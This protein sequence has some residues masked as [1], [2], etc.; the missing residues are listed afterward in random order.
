[1][2]GEALGALGT[3]D[4]CVMNRW[5]DPELEQDWPDWVGDAEWCQVVGSEKSSGLAFGERGDPIDDRIAPN[6]LDAARRRFFSRRYDLVW[7]AEPRGYQPVAELASRPL[8]LDLHNVLSSVVAHKRRLLTHQPWL[9]RSWR[10]AVDDPV[11]RPG[12]ERRWR[13]WESAAARSCDRVV[14]CSDLD[15]SRVGSTAAVVPNCYRPPIRPAGRDHYTGRP[16]RIGFVGL[17]SYQPNF[18]AVHWFVRSV[19]PRVLRDEPLAEFHVIGGGAGPEDLGRHDR[20]RVLG[21]VPDLERALGELS[22]I[23]A[24]IRFGGGTRFKIL[25]GFAHEIPVVSTTIG[26]EGILAQD[27][28]HLLVRDD[29]AGFARAVVAVHR[30]LT[31][32]RRLVSNATQLFRDRYIWERGVAAVQSVVGDLAGETSRA[33]LPSAQVSEEG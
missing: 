22:V 7:C 9:A 30:D 2:V 24:P 32:R 20:V 6:A 25:E 17:L 4:V 10:Q 13:D 11:Y 1:M 19:L 28:R 14:V 23:V 33:I 12:I 21:F 8:V 26:A 27:G 15:R 16:L 31:L 5:R 3:V 29:P 18:D